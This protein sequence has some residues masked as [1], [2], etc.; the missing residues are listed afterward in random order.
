ML[1]AFLQEQPPVPIENIQVPVRYMWLNQDDL[2]LPETNRPFASRIRTS[3]GEVTM[4][5]LHTYVS[6][7]NDAAFVDNLLSLLRNS[8]EEM[9]PSVCSTSFKWK[10]VGQDK[11][12]N[13]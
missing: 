1:G 8:G 6:G 9:T 10:R 3:D 7:A 11:H 2:C 12:G 13:Y 5:G 4:D